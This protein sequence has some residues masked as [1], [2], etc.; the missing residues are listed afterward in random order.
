MKELW[1]EAPEQYWDLTEFQLRTEVRR[2]CGPMQKDFSLLT[3]I[4]INFW[5]EY[6]RAARVPEVMNHFHLWHGVCRADIYYNLFKKYPALY[7]WMVCPLAGYLLQRKEL[8]FLAE[9]RMVEVLSVSPVRDDGK[10]DSRLAK[11]Q[12]EMYQILQDRI[13]GS[14]TQKISSEQKNLN[15]NVNSNQSSE[16]SARTIALITNVEELDRRIKLI[17]EKR[18][19]LQTIAQPIEVNQQ[20][21]MRPDQVETNQD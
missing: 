9:E 4:R 3:R 5:N 13:Y 2:E 16:D 20:K 1:D 17:Q 18:R 11:V 19:A 8:E 7:A 21:L 10:V 6:E 12:V 15:V 14:V